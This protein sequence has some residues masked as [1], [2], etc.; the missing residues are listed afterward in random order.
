MGPIGTSF[1]GGS[2]VLMAVYRGDDAEL[3]ERAVCS[4]YANTLQPDSFVLVV[5]GPV[6]QKLATTIAQLESRFPLD[7]LRL[8]NNLGLAGALNAG[9][10]KVQ[11]DWVIRADADDFNLPHRFE[12]LAEAAANSAV[13]DIVG[14]A[15]LEVDS[16]GEKI[17]VRRTPL[18]HQNIVNYAK[19][20]NPFNHMAVAYR[21]DFA[22]KC[23]GY[24]QIHLKEDYALW[25]SM[26]S[27]GAIAENLNEILVYATAGH[28]MYKRRGGWR[29]AIAEIELQRHLVNCKLKSHLLA[30]YHGITRA[31]VFLLPTVIRGYVYREFLRER[32]LSNDRSGVS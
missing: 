15:I 19:R 5:D 16:S 28:D 31:V 1:P 2:T 11:T 29:Y 18:N 10:E 6:F 32:H 3:F 24:S 17:A 25:A 22:M 23:G 8:P 12:R 9:L 21:R 13:L 4:V 27:E 14:S 7:V 30:S 20:R 26:L